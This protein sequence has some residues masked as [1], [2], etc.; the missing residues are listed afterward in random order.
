M[1]NTPLSLAL[2]SRTRTLVVDLLSKRPR[3]LRELSILSGISVQ[4]VLRHLESLMKI[5]LVAARTVRTEKLPARK[6]YYLKGFHF[7]DFSVGDLTVVRSS[8]RRTSRSQPVAT[9]DE[10]EDLAADL[11]VRRRRIREKAKR[12]SR[13]IEELAEDQSRL[14]ES[15]EAM[16]LSDEERMILL[17]VFTEETLQDAEE[18]LSKVQGMRDARGSV[19]RLVMK[20]RGNAK[21]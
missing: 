4:G 21:K 20:V 18:S 10:L 8:R 15:I 3:T 13:M 17:T 6:I 16:D 14:V 9:I 19:D 11:I 1:E 7:D 2:S 5:N 12:L